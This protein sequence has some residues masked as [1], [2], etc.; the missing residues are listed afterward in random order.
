MAIEVRKPTN[1]VAAVAPTNSGTWD[2]LDLANVYDTTTAGDTSTYGT[3]GISVAPG[4]AMSEGVWRYDTFQAATKT[5]TD[6]NLKMRVETTLENGGASSYIII[7]AFNGLSTLGT[8]TS[9]PSGAT[10]YTLSLGT[11]IPADLRVRIDIG[12]DNSM[13]GGTVTEGVSISDIWV[14]GTYTESTS[15]TKKS[16][17]GSSH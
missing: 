12:N 15:G 3:V 6:C 11:E 13:G 5:Y 17:A 9:N 7:Q 10:T 4:G 16:A 8:L 1:S 14:E 2:N